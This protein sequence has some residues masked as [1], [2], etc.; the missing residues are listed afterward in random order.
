MKIYIVMALRETLETEEGFSPRVEIKLPDG[1]VGAMF[2]YTD[3]A[4]AK[5]VAGD[6]FR[7]IQAEALKE[8]RDQ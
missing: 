6:R 7:V 8:A 2:A 3:E 1:V 4:K 5:E